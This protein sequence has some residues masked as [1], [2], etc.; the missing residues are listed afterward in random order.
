MK[1]TA[2]KGFKVVMHI[3]DEMVVDSPKDRELKE[4][5]D[6][7]AEPVPWAQGLILRGDGFESMFYKK[8]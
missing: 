2:A 1:K 3:H 7:M 6:I 5:T 4:L 8:D